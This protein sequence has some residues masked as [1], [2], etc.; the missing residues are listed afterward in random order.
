MMHMLT[1]LGDIDPSSRNR[2]EL[3]NKKIDAKA[4]AILN[5]L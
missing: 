4:S 3:L 5:S 2:I 1:K